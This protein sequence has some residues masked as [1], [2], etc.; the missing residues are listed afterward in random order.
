MSDAPRPVA[1]IT[2]ASSGVG[3]A[4]ATL[5]ARSGWD[6]AIAA[7][8][9]DKL[10]TA[11]QALRREGARVATIPTDV[12]D[13]AQARGLIEKAVGELGRIDALVNNAGKA[14]LR[15][16]DKC[17]PEFLREMYAVNALGPA[18]TISAAWPHFTKQKEGCIVN[19]STKGTS[20]PFPGFFAYAAAKAAT[21]LMTLSCANEGKRSNIRAF[22]VAPGAIETPMLRSMFDQKVLPP[23]ACLDPGD[24]AQVIVDCIEGRRDGD[25]GKVIPLLRS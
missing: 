8:N 15:Q 5:L 17:D 3:L 16:I 7:R 14:A 2:G 11:A 25:N 24:V 12:G 21:N 18:N 13:P 4:T 19:V 23:D 10:E 9:P 6:L 20:D 22:T 1:V